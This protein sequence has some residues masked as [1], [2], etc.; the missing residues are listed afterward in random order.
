MT[1]DPGAAS[2]SDFRN[3]RGGLIAVGV[4]QILFGAFFLLA[5]GLM[6]LG[7]AALATMSGQEGAP[8]VELRFTIPGLL[9]YLGL[10]AWNLSMGIG[11]VMARRWARALVL[12]Q[13]WI[14]FVGG[15]IT[16]AFMVVLMPDMFL[17]MAAH[18]Q[19]PS[20]TAATMTAVMLI[21]GAIFYVVLPGIFILFYGSPHVKATCE[22]RDPRERWTDR[23]PLP[24]LAASLVA[25]AMAV[26]LPSIGIY[27]WTLPFFGTILTGGAGA[28]VA[29]G[30]TALLAILA[31]GL[32]RLRPAAWWGAAALIA[33]WCASVAVTFA[34]TNLLEFYEK[35][36][37]PAAQLE[38][39]RSMPIVT[40]SSMIVGMALFWGVAVLAYFAGIRRFF[41][42]RTAA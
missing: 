12:A 7:L 10:A 24:V 4:L 17:R 9:L 16:M 36:G 26:G 28:A 25:A 15:A 41:T 8:T 11:S 22:R 27:R 30:S 3:R 18:K 40:Q 29:L 20:E 35:M 38:I 23:C 21:F 14:C 13:S 33:V 2:Q 19:M 5:F 42:A 32:Y 37:Y 6:L 1:I 39:L 31:W 34:R